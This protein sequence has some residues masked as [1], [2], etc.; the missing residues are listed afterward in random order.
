MF[1]LAPILAYAFAMNIGARY[2][3]EKHKQLLNDIENNEFS[4]LDTMH[5]LSAGFKATFSRLAYDGIDQC[6]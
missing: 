1:K 3:I 6:R 4:G 5:H 2:L